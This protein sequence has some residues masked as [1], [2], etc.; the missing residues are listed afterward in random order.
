MVQ[1]NIIRDSRRELIVVLNSIFKAFEARYPDQSLA[2][3]RR[4]FGTPDPGIVFT[5]QVDTYLYYNQTSHSQL[6]SE[7][8]Y[9]YRYS[10]ILGSARTEIDSAPRSYTNSLVQPLR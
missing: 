6:S 5:K 10:P 4:G 8:A 3:A 9:Q 1:G 2:N 7:E